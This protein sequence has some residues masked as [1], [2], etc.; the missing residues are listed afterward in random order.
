[1]ISILIPTAGRPE[2]LRTALQSLAG[3]TALARIGRVFVSE[4][5]N[6]RR[7]EEICAAF[8]S[9]PITYLFRNP[10]SAMEH[11]RIL[12]REAHEN[13]YT[14]VLHDDD[15]WCPEH[16]Q[17]AFDHLG[18]NPDAVAYN[19]GH[20]IV[21]NENS[22]LNCDNNLF[23]WFGSNYRGHMA[24]WVLSKS[25]VLLAL[26]LGTMSHYSTLVVRAECFR[27]A[28]QVFDLGNPFDND[29]MLTFALS[30][31]GPIIFN[32]TPGVFVRRHQGQDFRS[33][34]SATAIGYM[35]KTTEWMIA[36]SG[37]PWLAVAKAFR[38]RLASCPAAATNTLV[39]AA[40]NPWCLPEL[41]KHV[42]GLL[43]PT[44][45]APPLDAAPVP[46]EEFVLA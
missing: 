29:R 43:Q 7:S 46:V 31:L 25:D 8:P 24:P 28:S 34:P 11:G 17:R 21:E 45:P 39:Q 2:M 16:L 36:G 37:K 10:T 1:M 30:N 5:G 19:C 9:L 42:D 15:W 14:A 22:L 6:D 12:F 41:A 13:E 44:A 26:L 4:N 23:A 32:P 20:Y 18:A 3:Q 35:R 33:F 40:M 38:N 27:S